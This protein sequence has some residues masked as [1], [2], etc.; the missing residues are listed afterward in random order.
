MELE[1]PADNEASTAERLIG[2]VGVASKGSGCELDRSLSRV[3]VSLLF[4]YFLFFYTHPSPDAK[5][6]RFG[7]FK[8]Y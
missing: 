2:C 1:H 4:I 3:K 6:V 8:W 5:R 7:V